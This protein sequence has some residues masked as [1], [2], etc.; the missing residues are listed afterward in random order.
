MLRERAK[1]QL[2]L[3][4]LYLTDTAPPLSLSLPSSPTFPSLPSS[5]FPL[6]SHINWHL[7]DLSRLFS[8]PI[9]AP[10][11]R[12]LL[13][14]PPPNPNFPLC[15]SNSLSPFPP[16]SLPSGL[17][18]SLSISLSLSPYHSP[19]LPSS[20][21]SIPLYPS[22]TFSHFMSSSLSFFPL[23]LLFFSLSF[24]FA[25]PPSFSLPSTITSL[26]VCLSISHPSMPSSPHIF[27]PPLYI[28]LSC[29]ASPSFSPSLTQYPLPSYL[30]SPSLPPPHSLFLSFLSPPSLFL[31]SFSHLSLYFSLPIFLFIC[32]SPPSFPSHL[33]HWLASSLL[34]SPFSVSPSSFSSTHSSLTLT[35]LY[36]LPTFLYLPPYYSR[37]PLSCAPLTRENQLVLLAP[38]TPNFCD[39]PLSTARMTD[40]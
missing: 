13:P 1:T 23:F 26:Y 28:F 24:S 22:L 8:L 30:S 15:L 14:P 3:V 27:V 10:L 34:C 35:F 31:L 12:S 32:G 33:S 17:P 36:S 37:I 40:W 19:Y 38:R 2:Y 29:H 21:F 6:F 9:P 11:P 39:A 18:A 16:L 4:R 20:L 7:P 25:L 5:L